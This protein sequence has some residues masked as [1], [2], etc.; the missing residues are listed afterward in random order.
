MRYVGRA[1]AP[2]GSAAPCNAGGR[3]RPTRQDGFD[4]SAAG[5]AIGI[6]IHGSLDPICVIFAFIYHG[7]FENPGTRMLQFQ[8]TAV[9]AEEEAYQH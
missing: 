7:G 5:P 6:C 9:S 2:G 8:K 3:V 4:A 1:M